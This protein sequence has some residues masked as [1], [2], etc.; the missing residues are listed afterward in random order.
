MTVPF[1]VRAMFRRYPNGMTMGGNID[2]TNRPK[3]RNADGSIST[4]RS[5][6]FGDD[7]GETLIPTVADDGSRILSDDDAIGQYDRTGDF[8]GRFDSPANATRYAQTLHNEQARDMTAPFGGGIRGAFESPDARRRRIQ[9]AALGGGEPILDTSRYDQAVQFGD[10]TDAIDQSLSPQPVQPKGILGHLKAAAPSIAAALAENLTGGGGVDR[11]LSGAGRGFLDQ[12][13]RQQEAIDREQQTTA[14][15]Q[16]LKLALLDRTLRQREID[17]LPKPKLSDFDQYKSDPA[18]WSAFK[19]AGMKPLAPGQQYD[20]RQ[21]EDGSWTYIPRPGT[22][23]TAPIDT[24]VTAPPPAPL[25]VQGAEGFN[26]VN[27]PR[28]APP[29]VTPLPGPDGS[30]LQ[31]A[32]PETANK[33]VQENNRLITQIDSAISLLKKHK[34]ATGLTKKAVRS[35]P[36]AGP[37]L[38]SQMGSPGDDSTRVALNQVNVGTVHEMFGGAL[39]PT[40]V[41]RTDFAPDLGFDPDANIRRLEQLRAKA[42]SGNETIQQQHPAAR[43]V[44]GGAT[45][46]PGQQSGT[47][48]ALTPAQYQRARQHYSDE[49]IRAGGYVIP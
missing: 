24:G 31:P 2:L 27:R 34:D 14:K 37:A 46:P 11:F 42:I 4:V 22:K 15:G 23:G 41:S 29:T 40:E 1:G 5:M 21:A 32:I 45:A 30:Q 38:T 48:K 13:G 7:N 8:L 39:T 10:E 33:A 43:G 25:V 18:A 28:N 19:A 12:Q 20:L 44:K 3:V 47:G 9:Q 49:E 6:S 26:T 36:F 35:I 16:Q 17:A